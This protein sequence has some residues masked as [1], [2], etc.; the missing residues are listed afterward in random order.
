LKIKKNVSVDSHLMEELK[1]LEAKCSDYD[2]IQSSACIDVSMNYYKD[3]NS[4]FMIYDEDKLISF[5]SIFAPL[6]HEIE[7]CGFTDPNYRKKGHFKRLLKEVINEAK[8]FDIEDLLFVFDGEFSY[9]ENLAKHLN[10]QP[11]LRE[12]FLTYNFNDDRC[13]KIKNKI[14][15]K[16]VQASTEFPIVIELEK[17]IFKEDEDVAISLT[18]SILTSENRSQ[19]ICYKE[20]EAIGLINV[21]INNKVAVIFGLGILKDYRGKGFAKDM[22]SLLIHELKTLDLTSINIEVDSN[23]PKALALYTGCGFE[24]IRSFEYYKM[25]LKK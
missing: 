5:I 12:Y 2:K 8:K 11:Y 22:L 6:K 13:K 14:V 1:N 15:I 20:K 17:N 24:R 16:K 25:N 19:Y 10:A 23:N 4:V 21:E 7:V 18:K 9:S 3:M